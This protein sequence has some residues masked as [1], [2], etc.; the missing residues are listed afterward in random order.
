MSQNTP[1]FFLKRFSGFLH[2]IF[3]L[4]ALTGV[5]FMYLTSSRGFNRYQKVRTS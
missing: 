1:S 2:F 3:A 5:G 4:I